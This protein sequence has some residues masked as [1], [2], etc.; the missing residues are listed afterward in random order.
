MVRHREADTQVRA[1]EEMSS[2]E[3]PTMQG[4]LQT[5]QGKNKSWKERYFVLTQDG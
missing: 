3:F 5:R 2:N 1:L 4:T